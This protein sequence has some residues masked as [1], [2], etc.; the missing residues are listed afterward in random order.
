MSDDDVEL[1][2]SRFCLSCGIQAAPG[3]LNC[4]KC[5]RPLHFGSAPQ[6][7]PPLARP[8]PLIQPQEM[9]SAKAFLPRVAEPTEVIPIPVRSGVL[10][11]KKT[12]ALIRARNASLIMLGIFAVLWIVQIVN[13]ADHY[14]LSIDYGIQPRRVADLPYIL[15]APFLHASWAHIEGN[16]LPLLILGFLV[17]YKGIPKFIGVTAVVIL[18][19]GLL[20]WLTSP[21]GS[22]G[23]GASGVVFG[24]F[25]YVLVRGFFNHDKVDIFMGL[26]VMLYYLPIFT[27]LLPAPHLGYQAHIGGLIGGVFCGWIFR[28][29]QVFDER[30]PTISSI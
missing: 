6:E 20:A 3:A 18:T 5:W 8:N 16:S 14:Q 11:G 25:G 1:A 13:N 27:L 28:T 26:L 2:D 9:A 24:W 21:T 30:R 29:R 12:T 7:A 4:D 23:V 19:S 15:S 10:D 17:A 22:I